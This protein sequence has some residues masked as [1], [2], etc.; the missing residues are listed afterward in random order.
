MGQY[1]SENYSEYILKVVGLCHIRI[2]GKY[3]YGTIL[4]LIIQLIYCKVC[5]CM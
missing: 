4:H 1:Y 2:W 5:R 3:K